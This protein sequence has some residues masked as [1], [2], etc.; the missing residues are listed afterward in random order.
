MILL[1]Y[2]NNY[3]KNLRMKSNAAKKYSSSLNIL[4][5]YFNCSIKLLADMYL[6]F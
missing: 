4:H 3:V 6:V 1:N 2:Q 5:N